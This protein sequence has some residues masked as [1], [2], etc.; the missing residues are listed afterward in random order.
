VG[1]PLIRSVR[2]QEQRLFLAVAGAALIFFS[3]APLAALLAQ[4]GTSA[5][6]ALDVLAEA[7]PWLLLA[8]S[9][10]LAAIVTMLAL[11]L[12]IPLGIL[13]GRTDAVGRRGA[14]VL[15]ALPAF[16]PPFLLAL[17]WFHAFGAGGWLGS[18]ASSGVLFSAVGLVGVL[19]LAFT[20][21]VTVL[22]ALALQGI[23]PSLEEAG[24]TA[25]ATG[26]VILRISLPAASPA[27]AL[28]VLVVFVLAFSEL[29][30]AMFLR[31]DTYPAAVFARMGGIDYAPGEALGLV[32]PLVPIALLVLF[33]E[34]R[35]VGARSFAVLALRGSQR[36]PLALGR[37]RRLASALLWL[38]AGASA[39]PV[40]FLCW[41]AGS[42]GGFTQVGSWLDRAP[43]NSLLSGAAAATVVTLGGLI[44]GHAAARRVPGSLA[45]D[46]IAVLAFVTPAAVLG[47]GLIELW[48]RPGLSPV[49]GT[50]GILVVGYVA[51]YAVIG[52]RTIA[53]VVAQSPVHLEEA[54]AVAGAG[55]VRRL[56]R[57]VVP[58]HARGLACAWLLVL[59]F[60]L[61]DLEMAVLFYPPGGEPSTVRIFTLEANGPPGVVAALAVAHVAMTA[62]VL[63]F[64]APMMMRRRTARG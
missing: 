44:L 53:S 38:A 9:V 33:L 55:F 26:R 29:G 62:V 15:H 58:L 14:A 2:G 7:R 52:I 49:Y 63:L 31:V 19:T 50:L 37:W 35:F 36:S 46:A 27:L 42:G 61:R 22:V 18:T 6:Q 13:V 20:P 3:L 23:D 56:V 4:A 30:V 39:A 11:A 47:V 32:L 34:R 1:G 40:L 5:R 17:G 16:L 59:V 64:S 60:C 43:L 45:L 51:R 57:I 24:R 54:A 12:G 8:R 48:N 25:A 41:R 21:V 10:A 28:A